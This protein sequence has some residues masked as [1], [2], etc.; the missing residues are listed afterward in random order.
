MHPF[1]TNGRDPPVEGRVACRIKIR[2][3]QEGQNS[4]AAV[5]P[6]RIGGE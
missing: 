3:R 2:R 1:A 4:P 5:P 6:Y